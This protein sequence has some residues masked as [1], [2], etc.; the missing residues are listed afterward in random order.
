MSWLKSVRH[1]RMHE[2]NG[3]ISTIGTIRIV[4]R[5]LNLGLLCKILNSEFYRWR[6]KLVIIPI[7][8]S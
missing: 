1:L 8:V 4:D 7:K 3:C 2:I 6:P 5:T